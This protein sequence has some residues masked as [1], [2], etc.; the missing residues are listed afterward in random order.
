MARQ[1][2]KLLKLHSIVDS[3]ASWGPS[4]TYSIV[5]NV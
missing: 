2:Q 3:V 5:P 1:D 4:D